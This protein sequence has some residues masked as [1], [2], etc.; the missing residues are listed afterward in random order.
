[1]RLLLDENIDRRVAVALAEH[2]IDAVDAVHAVDAGLAGAA[3]V[4]LFDW[5]IAEGRVL[6]TRDYAD[7]SRLAKAAERAGRS[8]PGVLFFSR[9]LARAGVGAAA[10]AVARYVEAHQEVAPGTVA[11]LTGD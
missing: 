7:F 6:L 2:G 8:F 1:M 9:T 3:D 10:A 5:A 4:A 11:W